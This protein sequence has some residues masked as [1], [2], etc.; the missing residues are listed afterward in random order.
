[1]T[2]KELAQQAVGHVKS[3]DGRLWPTDVNDAYVASMKRQGALE[4]HLK[5]F[6]SEFNALLKASGLKPLY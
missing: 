5:L 6:S 1:M 2:I 4:E 3:A